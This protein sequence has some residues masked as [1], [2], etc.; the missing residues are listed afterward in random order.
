[1]TLIPL[2]QLFLDDENPILW[3][4]AASALPGFCSPAVNNISVHCKARASPAT[5][6]GAKPWENQR[7]LN[8]LGPA[9]TNRRIPG[10]WP[11][12]GVPAGEAGPGSGCP[13]GE[14]VPCVI[15]TLGMGAPGE[16]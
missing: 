1:M 7:E 5:A 16:S 6:P 2:P 15:C 3:E 12:A 13:G 9:K 10:K 4:T 8:Q 11:G 14:T